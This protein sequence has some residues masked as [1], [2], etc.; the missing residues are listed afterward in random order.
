M[1]IDHDEIRRW[2]EDGGGEPACVQGTG[3]RDDVGMIRI[4]FPG[5]PNSNDAKLQK[6]TWDDFFKKFDER[7]LA[8]LYQGRTSRGQ[9]SNFYKIVKRNS[10]RRA[11]SSRR[12][13]A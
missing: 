8:L 6:I 1:T 7:N 9:R 10:G 11:S 12:S 13:A 5:A 4:E 2:T 3:D